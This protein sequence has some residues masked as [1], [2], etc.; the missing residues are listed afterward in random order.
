[1]VTLPAWFVQQGTGAEA[2]QFYVKEAVNNSDYFILV[3]AGAKGP[4]A[5]QAAAQNEANAENAVS[6]T[7]TLPTQA[8][9]I[10]KNTIPGVGTVDDLINWLTSG[11]LWVRIGELLAGTILTYVGLKA[12]TTPQGLPVAQQSARQTAHRTIRK[13]AE[14]IGAVAPK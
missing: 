14:V 5:S 1:M 7:Q 13:T 8:A 3:A 10:A 12:M 11:S 4:Y 2:S 9:N 6:R